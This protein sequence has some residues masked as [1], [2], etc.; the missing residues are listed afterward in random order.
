MGLRLQKWIVIMLVGVILMPG[1]FAQ[2]DIGAGSLDS[3]LVMDRKSGHVILEKGKDQ[4]VHIEGATNILTAILA[5][6]KGGDLTKRITIGPNPVKVMGTKVYLQ[7]KE[8]VPLEELVKA[9]L[10]YSANDA[11]LAIAEGISGSDAKFVEELNQKARA[12][13]CNDT[14]FTN[15]YGLRDSRHFS[16][17]YDVALMA[18]Y[19]MNHDT[20]AQFAAIESFNWTG[21]SWQALITNRNILLESYPGVTGVMAGTRGSQDKIDLIISY[22]TEEEDYILVMANAGLE[23]VFADAVK[24]L[25]YTR[26]NYQMIR[27]V[28]EKDPLITLVAADGTEISGLSGK[29]ISVPLRRGAKADVTK[30]FFMKEI[31]RPLKEGEPIGEVI[32]SVSGEAVERIPVV[33][34]APLGRNISYLNLF[35]YAFALL[36]VLQILY[37]VSKMK[38]KTKR[39]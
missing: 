1:A 13:G 7:E 8:R 26:T 30:E 35:V 10:V 15:S 17:A 39:R 32:F 12:I 37:R 29:S 25:E 11:A 24:I 18:R 19:A 9:A 23:T 33:S 16:T 27:I 21:T 20:F 31:R 2:P 28:D 5:I 3:Y 22:Q 38:R 6:E 4:Q 36:Y 14:V 34:A